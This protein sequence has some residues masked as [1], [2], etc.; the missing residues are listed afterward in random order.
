MV[1]RILRFLADVDHAQPGSSSP[2]K[3]LVPEP[4][5]HPPDWRHNHG[6]SLGVFMTRLVEAGCMNGRLRDFLN[7]LRA[8]C[9]LDAAG[10]EHAGRLVAIHVRLEGGQRCR[11]DLA[12]EG[13]RILRGLGLVQPAADLLMAETL[14]NDDPEA[15]R[16]LQ[17]LKPRTSQAGGAGPSGEGLSSSAQKRRADMEAQLQR[18]RA[19]R[20]SAKEGEKPGAGKSRPGTAPGSPAR[21]TSAEPRVPT[22]EV[23]FGPGRQEDSP[24][25][26]YGGAVASGVDW[27]AGCCD[28]APMLSKAIGRSRGDYAHRGPN[29]GRFVREAEVIEKPQIFDRPPARS[30]LDF[31]TRRI[32]ICKCPSTA[33]RRT[34]RRHPY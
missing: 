20:G 24:T 4:A 32:L 19:F 23:S 18:M 31:A 1:G 29:Q 34:P 21:P 30:I 33:S 12:T 26:C 17:L 7:A 28:V 11:S 25:V 2:L 8:E 15:L 9:P 5:E 27:A 10:R 13:R 6:R 3:A 16:L 14:L 22:T